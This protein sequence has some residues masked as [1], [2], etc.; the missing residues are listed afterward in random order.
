MNKPIVTS[1]Q[2]DYIEG[3]LSSYI[4]QS[5]IEFDNMMNNLKST[6]TT[7]DFIDTVALKAHKKLFKHE[8][9]LSEEAMQRVKEVYT[10]EYIRRIV[11]EQM[12]ED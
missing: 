1:S 6:Y 5:A 9:K 7:K 4:N 3:V 8:L 12:F 11:Q 10:Y 2:M